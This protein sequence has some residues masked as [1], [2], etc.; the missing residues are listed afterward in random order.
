MCQQRATA[1]ARIP[2]DPGAPNHRRLPK[3]VSSRPR[4][5]G[6]R[7]DAPLSPLPFAISATAACRTH[8]ASRRPSWRALRNPAMAGRRRNGRRVQGARPRTGPRGGL[9][10]PGS[11]T[12]SAL[13]CGS[14]TTPPLPLSNTIRPADC[15]GTPRKN[16]D[17]STCPTATISSRS[18]TRAPSPPNN[19]Q[20]LISTL[21]DATGG[22]H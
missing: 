16:R 21:I 15:L 5:H 13:R 1:R 7:R 11:I 4:R 19:P 10:T 18:R 20:N 12:F 9:R 6:R 8:T 14:R 17:R 2:P 3:F 22:R